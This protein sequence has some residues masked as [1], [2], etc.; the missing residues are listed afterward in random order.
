M[1]DS[2][3]VKVSITFNGL[4]DINFVAGKIECDRGTI[5]QEKNFEKNSCDLAHLTLFSEERRIFL[6]SGIF[7]LDFKVTEGDTEN[8]AGEYRVMFGEHEGVL[9]IT[10]QTKEP[11]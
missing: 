11:L 9:T 3:I 5:F 1:I 8:F 2:N 7:Y 4:L 6:K 10:K